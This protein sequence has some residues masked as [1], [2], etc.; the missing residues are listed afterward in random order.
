LVF[1]IDSQNLSRLFHCSV[2]K[3][4]FVA[5]LCDS[6]NRIAHLS[7]SV[8]NFFAFFFAMPP[9]LGRTSFIMI[10]LAWFLVKNFF[11]FFDI[12]FCNASGEGGI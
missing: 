12:I 8:N 7:L 10:S 1:L 4:L 2:F 11:Q 3:V 6:Y 9:N 5:V